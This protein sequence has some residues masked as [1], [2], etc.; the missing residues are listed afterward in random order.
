MGKRNKVTTRDIAEYTGVSQSTVS[1]IL[2]EKKNV[3]FGEETVQKVKKAAKSLGYQKPAKKKQAPDRSLS[4]TIMILCPTISNGYYNAVVHSIIEKAQEYGYT[5]LTAVTF[6]SAEREE[7]YFRLFAENELAGVISL[8]PLTKYTEANMLAKRIPVVLIGDK[9]EGIRFNSVELD[10]QRPGWMMAEHLVG[11]G[12]K[13]IAFISAPVVKKEISRTRRLAGLQQYYRD[14]GLDPASIKLFCPAVKAYAEYPHTG[15]E[16]RTGYDMTI[17]ALNAGTPVTA[18]VGNSDDIALGILAALADRGIRVP[19]D[20]SVAGFDN[21]LHSAMPQISLT[22]VEHSSWQ[23]GQ[24]AVEVIYLKNTR[25]EAGAG[26]NMIIRMEYDPKLI[27][28]RTTG[29]ASADS[30]RS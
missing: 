29:K 16:Y 12:H 3:S 6:R 4:Q 15:A 20:V 22:T 14:N 23:K 1:M 24:N 30:L 10:S 11:L 25:R 8:Y 21:N 9:P 13:H 26:S 28:R 17:R 18:F 2:S 19:E 7:A 27:V 5:T